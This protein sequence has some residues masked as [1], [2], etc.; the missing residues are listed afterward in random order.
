MGIRFRKY[1]SLAPGVRI[2]LT[3]SGVSLTTGPRGGSVNIGSRGVYGNA[4]LPG[5]GIYTRSRIDSK[6]PVSE[7]EAGFSSMKVSITIKDDGTLVFVDGN[8]TPLPESV[9][10]AAKKQKGGLIKD[11]IQ[12]KCDEINAQIEALGQIHLNTPQPVLPKFSLSSFDVPKPEQPALKV[13]GFFSRLI[14]P[15]R[16]G[17]E[18]ENQARIEEYEKAMLDWDKAKSQFEELQKI[19][20]EQIG[21][22]MAG[23]P[24]GVQQYLET[25]LGD[26]VWPRETKVSFA[27]HDDDTLVFEVDLPEIEEMPTKTA[28]VPQRGM[29]LSVKEMGPVQVQKLYMRHVHGV[30]FRIIG[31]AFSAS[32]K[33]NT[34][35]LS[36]YSQRPNKATGQVENQYLYSVKVERAAWSRINFENLD[37]IDI[38]E[39]L[40]QFDLRREMSKTGV[41]KGIAP[42]LSE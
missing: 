14:K 15:W 22:I 23:D 9:I 41:F 40:A 35:I 8:G 29:K 26:I 34:V 7:D 16:E 2:N 39:A 10:A 32:P 24:E 38:V 11:Y 37:S 19:Q 4:G 12:K 20:R 1:I 28:S 5:T 36:A 30:G 42:F 18:R 13:P 25:A 6:S 3:G 21:R 27:M 33:T 31:E 17:V